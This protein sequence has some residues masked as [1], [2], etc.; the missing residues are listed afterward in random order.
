MHVSKGADGPCLRRGGECVQ[1]PPLG[2]SPP[3]S[4]RRSPRAPA[5]AAAFVA[6]VLVV[7]DQVRVVQG[8][9]GG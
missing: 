7:P 8:L 2:D 5:R 4:P 3:S 9:P 1:G 6:E